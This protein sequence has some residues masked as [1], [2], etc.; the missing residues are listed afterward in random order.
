MNNRRSSSFLRSKKYRDG[1]D[2]PLD[3]L[4]PSVEALEE[5]QQLVECPV[6]TG[7]IETSGHSGTGPSIH[8]DKGRDTRAPGNKR[9]SLVALDNILIAFESLEEPAPR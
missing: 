6:R 7:L 9:L 4:L 5:Q 1:A 8:P 3:T 2:V